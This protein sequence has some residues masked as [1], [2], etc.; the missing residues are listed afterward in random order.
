[1]L[2]LNWVAQLLWRK[3]CQSSF[4]I[5]PLLVQLCIKLE[6]LQSTSSASRAPRSAF[7][8]AAPWWYR[9]SSRFKHPAPFYPVYHILLL[10][11][12]N[13]LMQFGY[14]FINVSSFSQH[15]IGTSTTF[16]QSLK[17]LLLKIFFMAKHEIIVKWAIYMWWVLTSCN[18][19]WRHLRQHVPLDRIYIL[20]DIFLWWWYGRFSVLF[21]EF[22]FSASK[23]R[24]L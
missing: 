9:S 15:N 7:L 17:A 10:K 1:M 13:A 20:I 3:V 8:P 4:Y 19:I 5:S 24:H 11:G 16:F 18:L 23:W 2:T 22:K 21:K 6:S 12:G 14:A